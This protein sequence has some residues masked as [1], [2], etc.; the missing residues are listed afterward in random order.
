MKK[1][2]LVILALILYNVSFS[3]IS[4]NSTRIIGVEFPNMDS[5]RFVSYD[6][7]NQQYDTLFTL[8]T[9]IIASEFYISYDPFRRI[10]YFPNTIIDTSSVESTFYSLNMNTQLSK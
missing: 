1:I 2:I 10:L 7:S 9:V 6:Y 8:D 4:N 3:Q 5:T